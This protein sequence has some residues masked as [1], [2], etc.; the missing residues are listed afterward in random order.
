MDSMTVCYQGK[1]L[2]QFENELPSELI[3]FAFGI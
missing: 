3:I 1:F 2:A